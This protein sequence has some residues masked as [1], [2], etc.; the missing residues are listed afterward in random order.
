M[1]RG[2]AVA[3]VVGDPA[4]LIDYAGA[5]TPEDLYQGPVRRP[6]PNLVMKRP[7]MDGFADVMAATG[8]DD[9]ETLITLSS[10]WNRQ[11]HALKPDAIV[12]FYAPVLWLVGPA[13]APTFALGSGLTLPP[14]LGTSFPRLTV[15]ST[16]LAEEGVMLANAN[17]A[18]MRKGQPALA[19]LSD[20][21]GRCASI[22]YG[23]PAFDP[24]LQVRRTHSS[25]LLGE[26]PNP[27]VPPA[28]QRV[29]AL[30]D[31][32]C[33]GIETIILALAGLDQ[34]PVDVCVGGATSSMRRFLEQQPNVKVWKDYAALLD[35]SAAVSVLIHHG[36]QDV[37][38][39]CISL[40]RP[41]L[42]IPWTHEQQ[43]FN[44]M[45]QW[46]AY[47]WNKDT[48]VT[49]GEL[50]ETIRAMM[51]DASLIVAA[52]HHAR[53]LEQTGLPDALPGI[54]ERIES[55]GRA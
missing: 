55:A 23:V 4:A 51:R 1:E 44:A 26:R 7:S 54:I 48:T 27:A 8:F 16:P 19:S 5:W 45:V 37:G 35:H 6:V 28:K 52:Q 10:L 34:T 13:H 31:I 24:Y 2:H 14:M 12:G 39:R 53:Q 20:V 15:D 50:A 32:Y 11:L 38:Q 29:A 47:T 33:P 43:I 42:I 46:M 41:Q 3:Y 40:G 9:K 49:I 30:L 17:A 36:V 22:L 25:G 21:L 18:L